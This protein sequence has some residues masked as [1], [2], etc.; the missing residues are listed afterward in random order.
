MRW[1]AP[2]HRSLVG[3]IELTPSKSIT[4][5]LLVLSFLSPKGFNL[6]G[7]SN[8][9]DSRVMVDIAKGSGTYHLGMA[10]TAMRFLTAAFAITPGSFVLTG[11]DR[12]LQRPIGPLVDALRS[13]GAE[14][15]YKGDLGC[16]PLSIEGKQL[17]GGEVKVEGHMSS[18]FISALMLIGPFMHQ[19][20][21][22]IFTSPPLSF[23]YIEM[24]AEVIRMA[25]GKVV[26]DRE[27][28]KV[29]P[30][31]D[32]PKEIFVEK[33]WSAA[34]FWLEAA[35]L[36][37]DADFLLKGLHIPSI[38]GDVRA[39]ELWGDLGVD[40]QQVENGVRVQKTG[41]AHVPN[42]VDFI[43]HPDL[44]LPYAATIGGLGA[45][46][47]LIGLD[48]LRI[49]ESDRVTALASELNNAG[50]ECSFTCNSLTINGRQPVGSA[51]KFAT[52]NDHRMAMCL[53]PLALKFGE[54]VISKAEVVSKSYPNFWND[55]KTVGFSI[56]DDN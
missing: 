56:R 48:N 17:A 15:Q 23:P 47:H 38:Q 50:I 49:K 6:Q 3:E 18:Q 28:V 43:D 54:V 35:V 34:A 7:I 33:D 22:V 2:S 4:N 26:V 31:M 42:T 25:G 36:A 16:P 10:G 24:T 1:V 9:D 12:L 13:I 55:M 52:W 41:H 53:A 39:A 19:G 51:P 21:Q 14:I 27:R 30:G 11:E 29:E 32:P 8:A 20:I 45:T 46:C 44:A 5:R 40:L 37:D